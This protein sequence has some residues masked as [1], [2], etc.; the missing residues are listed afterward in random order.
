MNQFE[1]DGE[2]Y[3]Q[4]SKHQKEWGNKLI[5]ELNLLGDE[6]V[7]DLGCGDGALTEQIAILVPNGNVV[8]IDAS[9]GMIRV[10]QKLKQPNLSFV[11]ADINDIEYENRFD[12]VFSN[13]ALH[14]VKNHKK[15]L[16]SSLKAL[17][18]GGC[19]TWNFGAN[20]NCENFCD[21]VKTVMKSPIY[22]NHFF[23]FE[24]PW[25]MPLEDDYN[26][27]IKS[28]GFSESEIS[29]ENADRYFENSDEM[30]KWIDQPCLV[31]F[32]KILPND[33]KEDFRNMVV[34]IM[35]DRTKQ[36]NGKCFETFRRLNVKAI[37]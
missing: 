20:G 4:A 22:R 5:S 37:K 31:P 32:L 10:A 33:K 25:Y 9:I 29:Y 6:E 36:P 12:I 24:W 16:K 2:K 30:I 28:V 3:R 35:I 26:A 34:K 7:L 23:D 27:L 1:F 8:G 21:I 19:I 14:W 13:A 11:C 18:R 15:L 17:K